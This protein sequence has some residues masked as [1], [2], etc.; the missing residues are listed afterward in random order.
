MYLSQCYVQLF[1]SRLG[2]INSDAWS[3]DKG[4]EMLEE[5]PEPQLSSTWK[6]KE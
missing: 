5:E 6:Q 2:M 1:Q 3:E 4:E